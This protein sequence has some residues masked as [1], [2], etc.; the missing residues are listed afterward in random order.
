VRLES[1]VIPNWFAYVAMF[2][3]PL[4]CIGLFAR[5]PIEKAAIWSL[6][7]GY[8][9]LPSGWVF[10]V[11]ILPPIDKMAI[12]GITTLLLCW[13]TGT[14][15]PRPRRALL[16]FLLA[17]G[18]V[19]APIFTSLDNSYEL[20]TGGKSVHGFYL[21]DGLK[22]AGRNLMALIPLFVG[23]RFLHTDKAR[24]LLLKA[25]PSAVLLYTVPMLFE[26]RMSPQLHRWVYGYFPHVSFAQQMRAGGFRPVVFFQ[27]GLTLAL[28]TSLAILAALIIMRNG[29][30][31]FRLPALGVAGYLGG[32]LVLCKSLGP[33]MYGVVFAPVVLFTRP[34]FWV[35]I[36]CVVSLTICAYPLLRNNGLA[37]T[38][39]VS[40]IAQTVS[41]DRSASFQTRVQNEGQLLAK[42]I[43]KPWFG[44]GGWGR[45]RIYDKWDGKDI[46]VTDG[47]WIIYFGVYGWLGYLSLFGLF[48][49]ALFK[50]RAAISKEV[51]PANLARSGLA[52]LL[53]VYLIDAI[54]NGLE[55]SIVFLISG[56][57]ASVPQVRRRSKD[58][59]P[60]QPVQ[61]VETRLVSAN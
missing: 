12:T 29:T 19:I 38:Q 50:A 26:V 4:V 52:L 21:S 9:L 37:P 2:G 25:L 11:P 44:W 31:I 47:G 42:A 14:S 28:F 16:L 61:V 30:R 51:T 54:P 39:V 27:H 18:F 53:T 43:Q 23:W 8:M 59:L 33:A 7:G 15:A 10:D 57:I 34:R 41:E 20:P 48:A 46:S 24:L 55:E 22:S 32:V 6:L 40:D 36:G 45:N 17:S 56:C 35:T 3:W 58:R 13:M 60:N 5:L 1:F 49:T